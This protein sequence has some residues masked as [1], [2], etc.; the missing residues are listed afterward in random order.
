MTAFRHELEIMTRLKLWQLVKIRVKTENRIAVERWKHP[1]ESAARS[2]E[3]LGVETGPEWHHA[4]NEIQRKTV[5]GAVGN[6]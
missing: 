2:F 4:W 5:E 6:E 1:L 3:G